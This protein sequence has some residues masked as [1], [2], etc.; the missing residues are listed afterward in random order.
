MDAWIRMTTRALSD[1]SYHEPGGWLLGPVESVPGSTGE[2]A[3]VAAQAI[4]HYEGRTR[5]VERQTA[6][7]ELKARHLD[8][9]SGEL[10]R[11]EAALR[12]ADRPTPVLR[13][14]PRR[15]VERCG[16]RKATADAARR[17]PPSPGAKKGPTA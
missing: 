5:D 10:E 1:T 9:V 7:G 11:H 3:Q 4:A 13:D 14:R 12:A 16:K 2:A 6:V 8:R 17:L 15:R